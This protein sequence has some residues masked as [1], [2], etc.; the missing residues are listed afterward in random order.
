MFAFEWL[1]LG[2]AATFTLV[3][4]AVARRPSRVRAMAVALGL[5]VAVHVVARYGTLDLRLFAPHLY[6]LVG[7]WL[8]GLV[9]HGRDVPASS[10]WFEAW[11]L[12]TD[13]ALRP[14]APEPPERV[15]ALLELGYLF[16]YPLVPLAFVLVQASGSVEDVARFWLL[17][18]SAGYGCYATLPWLLSRP[19]RVVT[20]SPVEA[21]GVRVLNT[22]VLGQF[23]HHWNTFPSG[24]V[25]VSVGAAVGVWHAWPA[26]GLFVGALALGVAL[27]AAV[28]RYHYV[29]DVI[30]GVAVAVA[31]AVI[32]W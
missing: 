13:A 26:A 29:I 8:P 17:V 2:Y 20:T 31:L 10:R 30:A 21:R 14:R 15:A 18:L 5:C 11:L 32:T 4:L 28:G 25:A 19:P 7:Y 9:V 1:V 23:S 3:A 16:C 27:G 6:L 24:H 12:R 22:L